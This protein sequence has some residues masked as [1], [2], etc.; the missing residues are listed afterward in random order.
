MEKYRKRV[1]KSFLHDFQVSVEKVL[2]TLLDGVDGNEKPLNYNI[3]TKLLATGFI[4]CILKGEY[5]MLIALIKIMFMSK[6]IVLYFV[7]FLI[8]V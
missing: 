5:A 1:P 7:L 4:Y 2:E 8:S 6:I 3:R